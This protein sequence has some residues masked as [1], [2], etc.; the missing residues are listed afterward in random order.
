MNIPAAERLNVSASSDVSPKSMEFNQ[1]AAAI[2]SGSPIAI[3]IVDKIIPSRRT[4]Q[5]NW[6]RSQP[7]AILM[8]N[9]EVRRLTL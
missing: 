9:S 2:A 6:R 7:M 8:P 1:W 5:S 4:N 3:P